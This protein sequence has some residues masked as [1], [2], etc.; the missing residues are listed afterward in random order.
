MT[1]IFKKH[2]NQSSLFLIGMIFC[3][4]L[5]AENISLEQYQLLHQNKVL[6]FKSTDFPTKTSQIVSSKFMRGDK[7]IKPNHMLRNSQAPKTSRII[8]PQIYA[9]PKNIK[10]IKRISI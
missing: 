4:S 2:C 10:S 8:D 1:K 6:T 3:C 7:N 9:S 5:F